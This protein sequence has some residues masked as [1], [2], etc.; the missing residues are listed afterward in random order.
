MVG[1]GTISNK[2][3]VRDAN[4]KITV[5]GAALGLVDNV[6]HWSDILGLMMKQGGVDPLKSDADSE[7]KLKD[8]LT[9]YSLF[10]TKYQVWDEALPSSTELF[11]NGKLAFYFAPS[12]RVFNIEEMKIPEFKYDITTVPQLP[13]LQDVP[14]TK[15]IV[16]L[17]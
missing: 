4:G 17:I 7:K 14:L 5:A 2:L 12:W 3:T 10:R 1:F 15:L 11:A 6:D 13:T 9:Y 16:R 8:V